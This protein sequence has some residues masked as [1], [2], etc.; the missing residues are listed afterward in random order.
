VDGAG[1]EQVFQVA[2]R[3][4]HLRRQANTSPLAALAE[5]I[6]NALDADAALV[7]VEFH[8]GPLTPERVVIRDDDS[9][10]TRTRLPTSSGTSATA[11][12]AVPPGRSAL[13]GSCT[14]ARGGDASKPSCWDGL[15]IGT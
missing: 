10:M 1:G 3:S 6:W 9:G 12:R 14:V 13:A 11:G 4:D 8:Q 2:A 15:P 7:E 5:C